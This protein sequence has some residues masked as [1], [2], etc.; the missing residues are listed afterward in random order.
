MFP[1]YF[2]KSNLSGAVLAKPGSNQFPLL[3]RTKQFI[4]Y[5][6]CHETFGYEV[7]LLSLQIFNITNSFYFI[8]VI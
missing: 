3:V 2:K 4:F 5:L 6:T 7:K 1:F 8:T